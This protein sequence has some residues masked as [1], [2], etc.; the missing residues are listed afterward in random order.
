MARAADQIT[1]PASRNGPDGS[2]NGG[3]SA[4]SLVAALPAGPLTWEVTLHLPPPLEQPLQASLDEDG[5]ARAHHGEHLVLS[6]RSINPAAL[7]AASMVPEV[8]LD[9]ARQAALHSHLLDHHPFPRCYTCGTARS[10]GL[11]IHCGQLPGTEVWAAPVTLPAAEPGRAGVD[12]RE[13]WA[14]LDCPS[15]APFLEPGMDPVV[16]GRIAVRIDH[17]LPAGS[18]LA[19]V[20]WPTGSEGRRC[21]SCSAL[22]SADGTVHAVA[23]ATWVRVSAEQFAALQ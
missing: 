9:A 21:M 19:A 16:L 8:A 20:A 4:G 1:I 2:G 17:P 15:A 10:D 3:Y 6:A 13:A 14:A 12:L 23:R 5:N 18:E 22:V 7:P 11:G